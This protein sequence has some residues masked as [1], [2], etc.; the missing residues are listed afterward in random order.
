M[1]SAPARIL[2]LSDRGRLEPGLRA[3]VNVIDLERVREQ[4]PE[5]VH[6]FP[7]GAGRYIQRAVGY[8][9]TLCNG[10]VILE[11]DEHTGTRSGHVIRNGS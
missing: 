9:A 1:T 7:G 4:M 10:E 8:R 6:D 3:D 5:Y 11:N 2:G